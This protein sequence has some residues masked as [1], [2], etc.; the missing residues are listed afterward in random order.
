MGTYLPPL[1]KERKNRTFKTMEIENAPTPLTALSETSTNLTKL[2]PKKFSTP[3]RTRAP[4]KAQ[5]LPVNKISSSVGK[6]SRKRKRGKI[7]KTKKITKKTTKTIKRTV[8]RR[9]ILTAENKIKLSKK[10]FRA[11]R[12]DQFVIDTL[13]KR[14]WEFLGEP[15]EN[16]REDYPTSMYE[17][18]ENGVIKDEPCLYWAD[19]DDSRALCGFSDNHLISSI[20]NADKSL[21]KV[22]QQKL[23]NDYDWFPKCFTLPKERQ[24]LLDYIQENPET[25]WIA[26]PRDSYGGFGMCVFKAGTPEFLK[27]IQR[28]TTFAVQKY[29]K[30]PYLFGGKYKFHVR[31][32]MVVTNAQDP[33]RA[34]LWKNAQMQFATH[35]FNLN[36]IEDNFN[37]YSHITNY[38]VNNEK[39]NKQFVIEDKAGIGLGT[40]WSVG[41][42]IDVMTANEPKFSAE[43]FWTD[44]TEIARVVARKLTG[45][46]KVDK[47]FATCK[48]FTTNHFEVYGLDI[49]MDEDCNLALTE[50]NT[51]PGLDW[52][53][54]VLPN[55]VFCD[56]TVVANAIT[57]GIINDTVTLLGLDGR[58]KF[59]SPFIRLH[60][61]E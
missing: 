34:Y 47:P 37:K 19:D 14:G 51:Q 11:W 22:Y 42:F 29:M 46:P 2:T 10:Q 45:N 23:F 25:Y 8:I 4:R 56:E 49:I 54:P 52:T 43:K 58:R 20:P 12:D 26:K 3:K 53:D 27:M 36:Q 17:A 30:N 48:A 40:E 5:S 59:Y 38:K 33:M 60:D 39:K 31:G 6:R 7:V 41:K 32:Y 1:S 24:L 50:A 15:V 13:V 61:E 44:V 16:G 57:E 55:G 9:R 21:T 18:K 28:K 35:E